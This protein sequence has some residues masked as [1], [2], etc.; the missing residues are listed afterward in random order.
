MLQC[1]RRDTIYC[2]SAL[3]EF[4]RQH[5]YFYN[6][7]GSSSPSAD[8]AKHTST[9]APTPLVRIIDKILLKTEDLTGICT[10]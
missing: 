2:H 8:I 4:S 1:Q 3:E 5:L 9:D 7:K 10:D 6:M